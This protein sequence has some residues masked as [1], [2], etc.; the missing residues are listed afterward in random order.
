[1][2]LREQ[3]KGYMTLEKAPGSILP[4]K[5]GVGAGFA[6]KNNKREGL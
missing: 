6:K 1:M 5:T 3:M 2:T 4:M